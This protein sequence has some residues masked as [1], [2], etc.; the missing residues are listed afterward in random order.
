LQYSGRWI[1]QLKTANT[2]N[3]AASYV[4]NP[5]WMNIMN[6]FGFLIFSRPTF[7]PKMVFEI[8]LYEVQTHHR[9]AMISLLSYTLVGFEPR[10]SMNA[11]VFYAIMG[12]L[13]S[14]FIKYV[15]LYVNASRVIF[16]PTFAK[17]GLPDF[18]WYKIPKR[19]K[20][21]KLPRTIPNVHK[22]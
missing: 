5:N 13:S 16:F 3:H 2:E 9:I 6:E 8:R 12:Y 18:S 15:T 19:E 21:T 4:H 17:P 7:F 22:I 14:I 10:S 11:I 1:L 20:Y